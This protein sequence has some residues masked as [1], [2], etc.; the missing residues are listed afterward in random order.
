MQTNENSPTTE[1]RA[2]HAVAHGLVQGVGFR[3]FTKVSAQRLGVAGWVRN[4]EDGSVEIWAEGSRQHLDRFIKAVRQGPTHGRVTQ[5]D[6]TWGAPKGE[7]RSF[8]IRY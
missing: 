1:I 2:V 4:A 6:L 8:R 7:T 3:Y 5:L